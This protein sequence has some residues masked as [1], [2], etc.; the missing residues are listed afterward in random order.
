MAMAA[1]HDRLGPWKRISAQ[2]AMRAYGW[3]GRREGWEWQIQ[4]S[5][6]GEATETFLTSRQ[7]RMMGKRLIE[8]AD[9]LEQANTA[10]GARREER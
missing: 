5:V 4:V 6:L 1:L 10:A 7:A 2:V 9:Q 8:L 3:I